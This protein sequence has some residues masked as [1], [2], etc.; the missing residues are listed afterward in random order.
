MRLNIFSYSTVSEHHLCCFYENASANIFYSSVFSVLSGVLRWRHL[1]VYFILW[2]VD[3]F[4][5]VVYNTNFSAE[6]P[7]NLLHQGYIASGGFYISL[8]TFLFLWEEQYDFKWNEYNNICKIYKS[9]QS[10]S[11]KY[12]KTRAQNNEFWLLRPF[13]ITGQFKTKFLGQK[14]S[15][16]HQA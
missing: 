5:F 2:L 9:K 4:I 3:L 1:L 8:C 10:R 14:F 6:I 16:K 12:M 11:Y 7:F 13:L 15:Y